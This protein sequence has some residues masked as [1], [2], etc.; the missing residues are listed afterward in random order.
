MTLLAEL[1]QAGLRRMMGEGQQRHHRHHQQQILRRPLLPHLQR[2]HRPRPSRKPKLGASRTRR[3]K[4]SRGWFS[5]RKTVLCRRGSGRDNTG[6]D[7]RPKVERSGGGGGLSRC[8]AVRWLFVLRSSLVWLG[9][10]V[11]CV[12]GFDLHIHICLV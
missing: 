1:P 10:C 6:E 12:V 8:I 7:Q 11:F 4:T 2:R 5:R 3:C 9:V